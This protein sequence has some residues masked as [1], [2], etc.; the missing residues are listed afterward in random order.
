MAPGTADPSWHLSRALLSDRRRG[1]IAGHHPFWV[2]SGARRPGNHERS[3]GNAAATTAVPA[4][5]ADRLKPA[6]LKGQH[7]RS[8]RCTPARRAT[9]QASGH[10]S[11]IRPGGT[12][13]K[14]LSPARSGSLIVNA[15]YGAAHVMVAQDKPSP[16]RWGPRRLASRDD[17]RSPP[18]P[19]SLGA[20]PAPAQPG[21]ST[22]SRSE[23]ALA[24]IPV[25]GEPAPGSWKALLLFFRSEPGVRLR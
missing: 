20:R 8:A 16:P 12:E 14:L 21:A 3:A 25:P 4:E 22:A 5:L 24:S 18:C 1:K 13:G 9:S 19:G 2:I 15:G 23:C 6:Y 7:R 17:C 11:R 10:C